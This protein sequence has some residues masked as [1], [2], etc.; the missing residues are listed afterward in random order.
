M[1]WRAAVNWLPTKEQLANKGIMNSVVC[2]S[3][4]TWV[5]SANHLFISC[6][7]ASNPWDVCQWCNVSR[8]KA[9][10]D[11]ELLLELDV[12]PFS[13]GFKKL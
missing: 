11:L 1:C 9:S 7:Y 12:W 3:C 2:E 8:F 6:P 5:E 4:G 10:S 13:T